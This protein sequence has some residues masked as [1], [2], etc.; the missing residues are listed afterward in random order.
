MSRRE[1][2]ATGTAPGGARPSGSASAP[3]ASA[4]PAPV[5]EDLFCRIAADQQVQLLEL[6]R[7]Q[8][9]LY[10]H[11]LPQPNGRRTEPAP[12]RLAQ[13]LLGRIENLPAVS[14]PP[15]EIANEL[16]DPDQREAVRR[17]LNTPDLCLIRG[18][19]GTGKSTVVAEIIR[20]ATARGERVLL[21]ASSTAGLDH[22]LELIADFP[23]VLAVRC[24]SKEE[25]AGKLPAN[26]QRLT[27]PE[28]VKVLQA[29]VSQRTRNGLHS[30]QE[31]LRLWRG[32]GGFWPRLEE[33]ARS[34]QEVVDKSR[35]LEEDRGALAPAVERE[36]W[37]VLSED[38]S[39]EQTSNSRDATRLSAQLCDFVRQR[40]E[41]LALADGQ[42]AQ[43]EAQLQ[44][45]RRQVAALEA[46][47]Q[48][49]RPL[50]E[51]R[52]QGRWWTI[53]WWRAMSARKLE[54]RCRQLD[55]E[56]K[57]AETA[58][59]NLGARLRSLQDQRQRTTAAAEEQRSRIAQAEVSRR[60]QELSAQQ[61][62][63]AEQQQGLEDQWRLE[64]G[65]LASDIPRPASPS[66]GDLQSAQRQ[67]Q[68]RLE[69]MPGQ[70]ELARQWLDYLE[71][72]PDVLAT[73]LREGANI[74]AVPAE[75]LAG[76]L[77]VGNAAA[78][79]KA[80]TQTFD[81]LIFEEAE[82]ITELDLLQAARWARRW[83]L[84][85]DSGWATDAEVSQAGGSDRTIRPGSPP[86]ARRPAPALPLVF[87]R[88]WELLHG[89]PSR[90]PYL[91]RQANDRLCCHLRSIP[92]DL[93]RYL[94][95]ERVA[96]HPEIELHIL[97]VPGRQPELAE[98]LFPPAMAI[99]QAKQFVYRELEEA[100]VQA[101]IH[102]LRWDT[103][104]SR[105]L[106]R[107]SDGQLPHDHQ[108]ALGPGIREMVR[109]IAGSE[110]HPEA[111]A[112]YPSCC[113]E[114]DCS[115]G[116]HQD[117][118][119][120]W[121]HKYLRLRDLGRTVDLRVCQR[122]DSGL[123]EYFRGLLAFS[124]SSG[125]AK[126]KTSPDRASGLEFVPV[127]PLG[128]D[129]EPARMNGPHR[130]LGSSAA[131]SRGVAGF[132]A[133]L[134]DSRQ[135]DRLPA[136]HRPHLP[137]CGY[138]NY[139]EAQAVVRKL[140]SLERDRSTPAESHTLGVITFSPAQAALIRR[141]V[142]QDPQL[143][144]AGLR[145]R[146]D[147]PA[148]FRHR[149]ADIVLVSLTRSHNHRAVPFAG[150]VEELI[151]ALTRARSR[152]IVFGDAGTVA[153]RLQWEGALEG[154]EAAAAERERA[155]LARLLE[156]CPGPPLERC[157]APLPQGRRA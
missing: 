4:P 33:I 128:R 71:K 28:Q 148:G 132:E 67:W 55:S 27:F 10:L 43:C 95:K 66:A 50:R 70:L 144:L 121:V 29:Q 134:A 26:L 48:Q 96:D 146:I 127:P 87:S 54:D 122:M 63:L 142:E 118:A 92:P 9:L 97:S 101:S 2:P 154:L 113:L 39:P 152:L 140:A 8:G 56:Q 7:R 145:I 89:D 104:D 69:Q 114:F 32:A 24:L 86:A 137:G 155:I 59:A 11:Q 46:R 111:T 84:V 77:P 31:R 38:H 13:I 19:P 124:P 36:V 25:S 15:V 102:S 147:L 73:Q 30:G 93:S 6:A 3:T 75:A 94:E 23:S 117:R 108:V 126:G 85:A 18:A 44:E 143:H 17:A 20:Q 139:F 40:D 116:W 22:T 74:V 5:W 130:R 81:L 34:W 151:L 78:G 90:L 141:L 112:V 65:H 120:E 110:E 72:T 41:A 103:E 57:V 105:L 150:S 49:L 62:L 106:L 12:E 129:S 91:W 16:L 98:I 99:E 53:A 149:E 109:R 47:K 153:R 125:S 14:R 88:L 119:E 135:R 61:R 21:T 115:A 76:S 83:L 37:D 100:A 131:R 156:H 107:L 60:D 79:E 51:A 80:H 68:E 138:V 157:H 123:V 42:I 133:D 45:N 64:C 52:S 35:A 1:Q 58:L 136:E 82:R